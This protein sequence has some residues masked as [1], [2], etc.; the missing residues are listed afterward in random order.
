MEQINE[1]QTTSYT[2]FIKKAFDSIHREGLWRI[3]KAYGIPDKLIRMVKIMYD[4]YECSV[5]D[6]GKQTRWFKI[7]TDVKQGCVMSGF[8]LLLAID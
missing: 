3:M 8:L 4:D 7:T 6:E 5:L 1:R 2:H